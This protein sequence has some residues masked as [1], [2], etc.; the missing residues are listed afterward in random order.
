MKATDELKNEH[1]GIELM[2]QVLQ[3]VAGRFER[4]EET[5]G[6]D[7][8]GILEFLT[9]FIDKCHHG[10][11]EE[12]LFPALEAV[13]VPRDGGPIGVLL[14]EHEQGR[15][16]VARLKEAVKS[17]SSGD[18]AGA[19]AVP[20]IIDEYT[21]LLTQHMAKENTVLFPLTEAKLDSS[22]DLKLF[23]A[24]ERLERERIGAG[25]HEEFHGLL[26]HLRQTY[27]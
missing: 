22:K 3:A 1:H 7:L 15:V 27:L 11:E 2:L 19:A 26:D 6:K 10:K 13:G 23:E 16:L 20:L 17:F 8:A 25:K 5:N 9:V 14:R 12:F 24:F 4:G 18:A 21:A